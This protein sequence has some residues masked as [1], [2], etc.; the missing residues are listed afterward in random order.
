MQNVRSLD[1][2]YT[3]L[4]LHTSTIELGNKL[5]TISANGVRD[6]KPRFVIQSLLSLVGSPIAITDVSTLLSTR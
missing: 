5:M 3:D 4:H 2:V 1:A 6:K